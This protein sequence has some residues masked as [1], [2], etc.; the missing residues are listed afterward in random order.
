MFLEKTIEKNP[1]LV[2]L[3]LEYIKKGYIQPDTYVIDVDRLLINAKNIL[4]AA[5]KFNIKLYFMTKQIGRNPYIGKK[6][7][8]L[9]YEGAVCVDYKEAIAL[10]KNGVKIGHVG[11]LVQVPRNKIRE[12]IELSPE[13]ITVYTYEKAQEISRVAKELDVTVNLMLRVLDQDDCIY[14]GQNGGVALGFIRET[15]AKIQQLDNVNI[16]GVTSF[17]C[18]LYNEETKKVEGTTN[19]KTIRKA[20]KIL[21]L[22]GIDIEQVNLPSNTSLETIEMI[23]N[24]GGTHGEPGHGLT[25]TTPGLSTQLEGEIPSIVYASE[26]SHSVDL[27]SYFYGGGHYRRSHMKKALVGVDLESAKL[28]EVLPLDPSSI[29]YYFEVNEICS[30]SQPVVTAFRTQ[31][32]VTRSDVALVEGLSKGM[33]KIVDIYDSSGKSLRKDEISGG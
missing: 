17:P 18:F 22:M 9:G 21:N 10:G 1:E 19:L 8:E 26:I 6:L 7:V 20:V 14:E 31:I 33:P 23:K 5:E 32:F 28:V 16:T 2:E 12:I 30:V 15:A 29:D 11:H 25:G 4:D 3:A 24:A 13:I 27:K